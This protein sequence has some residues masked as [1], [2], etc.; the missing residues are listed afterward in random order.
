MIVCTLFQ[1]RVQSYK[2][3][4]KYTNVYIIFLRIFAFLCYFFSILLAYIKNYSYLC[5]K[6]IN[7]HEDSIFRRYARGDGK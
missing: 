6:F 4:M 1:Y 5:E 2:K 7:D 3:R